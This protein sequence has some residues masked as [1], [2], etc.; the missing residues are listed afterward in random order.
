[1]AD[2]KFNW[3]LVFSEGLISLIFSLAIAAGGSVAAYSMFASLAERDQGA[4]F[5]MTYLEAAP[6]LATDVYVIFFLLAMLAMTRLRVHA[7]A[8]TQ[9]R[10]H[11]MFAFV[12]YGLIGLAPGLIFWV[13]FSAAD[14]P[15]I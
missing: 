8:T 13:L 5:D 10:S 3:R 12:L 14:W 6:R 15:G 11:W 1:M 7:R 4:V 9:S 2:D